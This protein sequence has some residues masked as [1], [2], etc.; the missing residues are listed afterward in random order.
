MVNSL[1]DVDNFLA[2]G[3]NAIEGDLTFASDGTAQML[4][5]GAPCDCGRECEKSADV[6]E[7]L[8]YLRDGV[9][10]GGKFAGKLQLLY[11]DT[12]AGSLSRN[13]KYQAGVSL[14]NNLISHLWSNGTIPPEYM[15]NVILSAPSTTDK[16]LILGALDTLKH[17]GNPSLFLDHVGFDISGYDFLSIIA[18]TYE[19]LGI[20]GHRWQSDGITNCLIEWYGGSRV[21]AAISRR[22][23]ANTTHDYV[24][25]VYVWTV[26]K[27]YTVRRILSLNIDGLMTNVPTA[28]LSILKEEQFSKMYRLATPQDSPWTRIV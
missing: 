14:A 20:R 28:V 4:Y 8:S 27:P 21:K 19:E 9:N 3:V 22:T 18:N 5:H 11:V 2:G 15:L 10:E 24:D 6:A 16:D 25:K 17:A 12:K 13:A 26:D 1:E 23:S 7:Y